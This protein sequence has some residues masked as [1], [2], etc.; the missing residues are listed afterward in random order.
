MNTFAGDK[1]PSGKIVDTIASTTTEKHDAR[2]SQASDPT[3]A[4]Q[5]MTRFA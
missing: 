3:V 1:G 4:V 2:V 5:R